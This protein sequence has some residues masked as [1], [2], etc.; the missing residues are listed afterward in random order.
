MSFDKFL[1][2]RKVGM[3]LCMAG[4]GYF[5][6][7]P[8]TYL[9]LGI[10]A[11]FCV[12]NIIEHLARKPPPKPTKNPP[13]EGVPAHRFENYLADNEARLSNVSDTLHKILESQETQMKALDFIVGFINKQTQRT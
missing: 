3:G 7:T 6:D 9:M 8:H 5:C 1:G 11:V 4:V 2:L 10:Y 13:S 12:G